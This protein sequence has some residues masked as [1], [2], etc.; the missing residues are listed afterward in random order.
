MTF[1]LFRWRSR[2]KT[3]SPETVGGGV[4]TLT[5]HVTDPNAHPQ[6]LKK[7]SA[8]PTGQERTILGKHLA[9]KLAHVWYMIRRGELLRTTTEFD[10]A[11]DTDYAAMQNNFLREVPV[12]H[13]VTA[14]VLNQ[15]LAIYADKESLKEMVKHPYLTPVGDG[16]QLL[17]VQEDGFIV[18]SHENVGGAAEEGSETVAR[19]VYLSDG[20]ITVLPYDSVLVGFDQLID[21]TKTFNKT[22]KVSEAAG[23]PMEDGDLVNLGYLK[24][25][26]QLP[27]NSI[28]SNTDMA[29]PAETLGYGTW[30]LIAE[31]GN[32][33]YA[34]KRVE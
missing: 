29:D 31:L 10:A 24:R 15:I 4:E 1:K 16:T 12:P 13:V 17:Q 34:W 23:D 20:K 8:V 11:K 25:A 7:G 18:V 28:Y 5:S 33:G 6:Y 32:F 26:S 2:V 19:G 9:D 30:E 21:G 27:V 22:P 3:G 14:Y